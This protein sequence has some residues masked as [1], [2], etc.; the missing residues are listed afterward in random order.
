MGSNNSKAT[1][2]MKEEFGEV[3]GTIIRGAFGKVLHER[4]DELSLKTIKFTNNLQIFNH[5]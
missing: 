2:H 1:A 4:K 5:S 3:L